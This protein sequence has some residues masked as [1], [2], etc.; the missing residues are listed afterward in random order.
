LHKSKSSLAAKTPARIT[1]AASRMIYMTTTWLG[2][3]AGEH[4]A[5]DIWLGSDSYSQLEAG[6]GWG[7][8]MA[9]FLQ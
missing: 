9:V 3:R 6:L 4:L 1:N 8:E 5:Q 2:D 7:F